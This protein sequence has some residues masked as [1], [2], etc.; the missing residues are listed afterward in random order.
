M[1]GSVEFVTMYND[2][3]CVTASGQALRNTTFVTAQIMASLRRLS[4]KKKKLLKQVILK[5]KQLSKVRK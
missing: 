1:K 4:W 3:D 2:K 5:V